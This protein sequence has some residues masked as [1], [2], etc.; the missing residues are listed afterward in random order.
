M[1][2]AGPHAVRENPSALRRDPGTQTADPPQK[3][4][5]RFSALIRGQS[6]PPLARPPISG[7]SLFRNLTQPVSA[8]RPFVFLKKTRYPDDPFC[9]AGVLGRSGPAVL[10]ESARV[11]DKTGRYSI[12]GFSPSFIFRAKGNRIRLTR[13][14]CA[15]TGIG[16]PLGVLRSIFKRFEAAPQ[17]GFPPFTGGAIGYFGYEVKNLIEPG[18]PQRAADDLGLPDIYLLFFE[19]GLVVDHRRREALFFLYELSPAGRGPSR[20]SVARRF[21]AIERRYLRCLRGPDKKIAFPRRRARAREVECALSRGEFIEKVEAAKEYI[22]RGEI[23]Q[24]NLSQ[25][26]KFALEEDAI[27]VYRRLRR[28]NPSPFF[29]FLRGEGFQVISGSPE[30]LVKLENGFLETRP[31]AGTRSRGKNDREDAAVSLE[32]ILNEKERAEHVMLVDL[33]RNDLGR[34]AEAGSVSVDELMAIEDYSHVK[35]IVSNVRGRLRGG[36]GMID[37]LRAV[38]PGGTITGAPKIRCMEII[39]ELEPVA[40]G[41]YTG[42][43]GYL[44]FTGNMDLNILI[45]SLVVKDGEASLHVGAGIVSDSVPGREY[46]ETLY[47]AEAVLS[48]VL[49]RKRTEAFLEGRGVSR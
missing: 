26:L 45:R 23:F 48:A 16:D 46:D 2:R 17:A 7:P 13:G 8:G 3:K 14:A 43:L 1:G 11:S 30:R 49:G 39:D 15:Q 4:K 35:H 9:L 25:R 40:R 12:V 41:P 29:G 24:A 33:E 20:A 18:L 21:E 32:L 28:I 5:N 19:S 36:L 47:K 37:V 38:F 22:R 27:R 42:S 10:L 34:V 44:S 6:V 31:I